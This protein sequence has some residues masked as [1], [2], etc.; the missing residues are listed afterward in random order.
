MVTLVMSF[1]HLAPVVPSRIQLTQDWRQFLIQSSRQTMRIPVDR[2]CPFLHFGCFQTATN[3]S[4]ENSFQQEKQEPWFIYNHGL[5]FEQL[6]HVFKLLT[7]HDLF[8]S[9]Y[10]YSVVP[11]N[12]NPFFCWAKTCHV[13]RFQVI[14]VYH[15]LRQVNRRIGQE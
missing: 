3:I 9:C 4:C 13:A 8:C 1:T 10:N 7:K 14:F 12:L 11:P 5:G 15:F 2:F 6:G